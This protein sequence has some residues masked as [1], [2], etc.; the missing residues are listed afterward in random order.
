MEA[1]SEILKTIHLLEISFDE[2][3][4]E[5]HHSLL[6]DSFTF[7][8]PF[9]NFDN[10]P[11]YMA[12]LKSFYDIVNNQ[13]GTRHLVTNPVVN[14]TDNSK[15]EVTF[16]LLIIN[17]KSMSLMGT[18]VVK[19]TLQLYDEVWKCNHREIYTDQVFS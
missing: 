7:K 4:F 12:W 19:D 6:L 11:D 9:G 13:G 14:L 1:S 17:K 15:A 18:S 3:D 5:L 2:G 8:S 16:Y 10:V